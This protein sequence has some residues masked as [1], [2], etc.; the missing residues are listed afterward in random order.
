MA[1]FLAGLA[2][3]ATLTVVVAAT[4]AFV[5]GAAGFRVRDLSVFLTVFFAPPRDGA[6]FFTVF[7]ASF[8]IG[9]AGSLR[10]AAAFFFFAAAD[11][12]AAVDFFTAVDLL[13]PLVRAWLRFGP[14]LV[15]DWF[16]VLALAERFADCFFTFAIRNAAGKGFGRRV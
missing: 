12:F 8:L 14:A 2:A 13:F 5:T 10:G 6:D 11:F 7:L 9:V 15:L 3:G 4:G 16:L 1:G